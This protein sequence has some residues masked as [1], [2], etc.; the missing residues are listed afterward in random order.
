MA[1]CD[2]SDP[3]TY[4][5]LQHLPAHQ[6]AQ[7][8]EKDLGVLIDRLEGFV[9]D[10]DLAW[11]K[12]VRTRRD[13]QNYFELQLRFTVA[14]KARVVDL[15]WKLFTHDNI[16]FTYQAKIANTL[17]SIL[18]E[19]VPGLC[20]RHPFSWK[21]LRDILAKVHLRNSQEGMIVRFEMS[22]LT[23]V[24][25]DVLRRAAVGRFPGFTVPRERDD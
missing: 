15:L 10:A 23:V 17:T 11:N 2:D 5:L 19:K 1:A 8:E 22:E 4:V 6:Q 13:L 25:M 12:V 3:D 7:L 16:P 24:L 20:R 14:E 9:Q 21:V 18:K